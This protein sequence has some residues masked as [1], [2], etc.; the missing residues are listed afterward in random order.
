MK[1]K[2]YREHKIEKVPIIFHPLWSQIW[3]IFFTTGYRYQVKTELNLWRR[4]LQQIKLKILFSRVKF[5]DF[6]FELKIKKVQMVPTLLW[7]QIW[8]KQVTRME[9]SKNAHLWSRS[10]FAQFN[11]SIYRIYCIGYRY[12]LRTDGFCF[13]PKRR[14]NY[15][16][17]PKVDVLVITPLKLNIFAFSLLVFVRHH[18]VSHNAIHGRIVF[19]P[20]PNGVS[21]SKWP[22]NLNEA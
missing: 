13:L 14:T 4:I 17:L 19:W 22:A 20:I 9:I 7:T 15:K 18:W 5:P 1:S 2:V 21:E 11:F 6:S 12:Q 3:K 10:S 16:W 8:K